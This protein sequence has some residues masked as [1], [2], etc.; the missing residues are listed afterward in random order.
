MVSSRTKL[1][2]LSDY[3]TFALSTRNRRELLTTRCC[4]FVPVIS[5]VVVSIAKPSSRDTPATR[6]IT[7]ASHVPATTCASGWLNK[8]TFQR[9]YLPD[10]IS[11]ALNSCN[12][13]SQAVARIADRTAK[14]I[15]GVTWP[16]PR[17]LLGE[18]F[19]RR[20]AFP[21][22]CCI[23]NLKSLAQ[24]V[25]EILR[26]KQIGVTSLTFQ[27]HVT[28]SVTWSFDSPHAIS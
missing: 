25:F 28:S 27:G 12:T 1:M 4:L 3:R 2:W 6:R 21:I 11:L 26:F 18:I 10:A 16:R 9:H 23:P 15:V 7:F 14:N 19:L 5:A 22:Q 17:P 20:S 24:V 8:Q 13:R